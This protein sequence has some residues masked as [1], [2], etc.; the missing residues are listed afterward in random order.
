MEEQ[1]SNSDT[2]H[3]KDTLIFAVVVNTESEIVL[4][5]SSKGGSFLLCVAMFKVLPHLT[6]SFLSSVSA[7]NP[8]RLKRDHLEQI[9]AG[10][11]GNPNWYSDCWC[12]RNEQQVQQKTVHKVSAHV[13]ARA[14]RCVYIVL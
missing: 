12:R 5:L 11:S 2:S 4:N 14:H 9:L 6:A 1:K 10:T 7:K 13:Q 3:G 8:T